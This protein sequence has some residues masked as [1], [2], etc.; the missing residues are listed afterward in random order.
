MAGALPLSAIGYAGA[1]SL[2][3][4]AVVVAPREFAIDPEHP[5]MTSIVVGDGVQEGQGAHG[6]FARSNTFNNMAAIGPDFK[7]RFVDD[8]PV[9]NVDIAPTLARVMGVTL[10][11]IGMLRGRVI[12]EALSGG[13]RRP[14]FERRVLR[15]DPSPSGNATI[16]RYQQIG[17][18][19][20]VDEACRGRS[21]CEGALSAG[22]N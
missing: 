6:A 22:T 21:G 13:P 15:S 5:D 2:A 8:A 12:S 9:G 1:S 16:L 20:Y 18:Q 19:R 10:P 3:V 7:K 14:G 17:S 11:A 4:P